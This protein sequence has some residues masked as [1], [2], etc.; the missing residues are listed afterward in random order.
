MGHVTILLTAA[1]R[2]DREAW[3]RLFAEF[4]DEL[5]RLAHARLRRHRPV[6]LLETTVLVHES[7]VRFLKSGRIQIGDRAH[8]MAYAA[9]VMRSIIVDHLRG[10]APPGEQTEAP[11][12]GR[13]VLRVHEA[14]NE[15][16]TISERLARVVEM[17]Y[18]AG[19]TE[20][21]IG[22]AMGL[23]DRTVRRDWQKARLLLAAT[24]GDEQEARRADE[25]RS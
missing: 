20:T 17:R 19:M 13:E 22:E 25:N 2:G 12:N 15:L 7:Y 4:Y 18:F 16:A 14:L 23:T 10:A 9:R 1:N 3:D 6:T 11:A 5:R 21:E 24:L 8:F